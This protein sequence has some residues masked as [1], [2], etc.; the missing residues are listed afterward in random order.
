MKGQNN[1]LY[2]FESFRINTLKRQLSRDG[3]IL[4]LTSK[5]FAT[6]LFLVRRQ[7]E[8]IT[9]EELMNAVWF[10]TAVE[11]N[12]LTQQISTL[13]KTLGEQARLPRFIVTIPGEGYSFI[14]PVKESFDNESEFV[15]HEITQP[16]ATIVICEDENPESRRIGGKTINNPHFPGYFQTY[17]LIAL[18][19][20]FSVAAFSFAIFYSYLTSKPT[21]CVLPFKALDNNEKSS[22]YSAG[23]PSYVTAKIGTI[24]NVTVRPLDSSGK[25]YG[26]E[27]DV[28]AVG[29]DNNADTVLTGSTQCEGDVVQ[30]VVHLWDVKNSRQMWAKVIT[31]KASDSLSVQDAISEEIIYALRTELSN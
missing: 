26:Q 27:A 5:A 1:C 11:E 29:R 16:D 23:I 12:N 17:Q 30:V 31:K 2:D 22:L 28:L 24:P 6:L 18:V 15:T 3:K 13:R 4:P 25:Y 19:L 14:A 21:I 9:K 7:G 20:L 8:I 10:D